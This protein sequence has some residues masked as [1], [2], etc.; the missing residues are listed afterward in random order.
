VG[1]R[2]SRTAMVPAIAPVTHAAIHHA[3]CP[4]VVVPYG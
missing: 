4:V 3:T 2:R 1:R